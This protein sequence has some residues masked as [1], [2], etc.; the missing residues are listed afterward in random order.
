LVHPGFNDSF[1]I[2]QEIG[3]ALGRGVP[4]LMVKLG[5]TPVGFKARKQ[6]CT[7]QTPNAQGASA[8]ILVWLSHH[9]EHG[10]T[11]TFRLVKSLREATSYSD[12]RDAASRILGMGNLSPEILD[13]VGQAYLTNNQIYPRHVAVPI[14]EAIFRNHGRELPVP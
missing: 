4:V 3:W 1:W 13:A 10:P 12:A 2:Q 8:E 14:I 7:P 9:R 6:A 11:V 5:E